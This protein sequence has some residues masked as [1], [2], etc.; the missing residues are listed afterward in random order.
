MRLPAALLSRVVRRPWLVCS[1]LVLAAAGVG[2]GWAGVA[3][4]AQLV[5]K[6]GLWWLLA[7]ATLSLLAVA[8]AAAFVRARR[9]ARRVARLPWTP[10]GDLRPGV[11][12]VRGAALSKGALLTSPMRRQECVFFR[13]TVEEKQSGGGGSTWETV[14]DVSRAVEVALVD[15]TGRAE[16]D[17][18][19]AE[20]F[21]RTE[22]TASTGLFRCL[23]DTLCQTLR[24]EY[25]IRTEGWLFTKKMCVT[26]SVVHEGDELIVVGEV[27]VLSAFPP[28]FV[29]GRSR[30]IASNRGPNGLAQALRAEGYAA[31]CCL[32]LTLLL[33]AWVASAATVAALR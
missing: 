22:Q 4:L 21:P 5:G 33:L 31:G 13:L 2:L 23:P 27:A 28:Q 32:F 8:L 19:Q 25:G 26:E 15:G 14:L 20:V 6:L 12:K 17:L 30:L 1:L 11:H 18:G 7:L 3:K 10:L 16:I 24:E 9:F 29:Q